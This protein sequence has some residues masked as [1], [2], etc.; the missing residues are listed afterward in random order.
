MLARLWLRLYPS[1]GH[2]ILR[3]P[4]NYFS[5]QWATFEDLSRLCTINKLAYFL[6]LARIEYFLFDTYFSTIPG[7]AL[8]TA[9]S[10]SNYF[11]KSRAV[12]QNMNDV[13][14][15]FFLL[16]FLNLFNTAIWDTSAFGASR[17]WKR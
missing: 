1:M 15:Y 9:P 16:Y 7:N 12:L 2:S 3:V 6:R 5:R 11:I 10:D 13:R 14:S 17:I 8:M 4:R